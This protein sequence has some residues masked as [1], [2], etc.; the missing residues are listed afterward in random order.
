LPEIK[1]QKSKG[2][3]YFKNE[4][5]LMAGI[6]LFALF[7]TAAGVPQLSYAQSSLNA[8]IAP[9]GKLRVA[10]NSGNPVLLRRASDGKM[11]GG[12]AF[13]VGKFVADRLGITFELV[14]YSNADSYTQSFG[15]GEWDIRFGTPGPLVV[16][17]A[18]FVMDLVLADFAFVAAPNRQF[19]DATQVDRSG[20]KIGVGENSF[21]DQFLSGNVK[22][23]QLVRL[24]AGTGGIEAL[25]SGQAVVWAVSATRAKEIADGVRG[26]KVVPGAF[27]TERYMLTVPKQ[28][29]SAA[30]AKSSRSLVKQ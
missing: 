25:N 5:G 28:R 30:R 13:E 19:A 26:A 18:D 14:A 23:A 27:T 15:K 24:P 6:F 8:E 2:Q 12:V 11:V 17:K 7:L 21:S 9:T 16:D 22:S 1:F 20:V 10:M 29:S 4:E 3:A